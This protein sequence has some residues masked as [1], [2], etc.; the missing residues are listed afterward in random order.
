MERGTLLQ[1]LNVEM[2]VEVR[3]D[4]TAKLNLPLAY[5]VLPAVDAVGSLVSSLLKMLGTQGGARGTYFRRRRVA[6]PNRFGAKPPVVPWRQF[7]DV[8]QSDDLVA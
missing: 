7:P 4:S 8:L 5:L 6:L 2:H 3:P 1:L